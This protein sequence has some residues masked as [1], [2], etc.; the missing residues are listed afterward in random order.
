MKTTT[1]TAIFGVLALAVILFAAAYPAQ[2]ALMSAKDGADGSGLFEHLTVLMCLPGICAG[3]YI[4]AVIVPPRRFFAW[5]LAWTLALVY[6][7]GEE[8]SW[9]Q[10]YFGWETPESFAEINDQ[11]ETNLHNISSWLDMKPRILVE[12]FCF[13]TAFVL[14]LYYAAGGKRVVLAVFRLPV[15]FVPAGAVFTLSRIADWIPAN[16]FLKNMGNSEFRELIIACILSGYMVYLA[17]SR[18]R[19]KI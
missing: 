8:A 13:M 4:M 5:T 15:S 19:A 16:E 7:A 17:A 9:G 18:E 1:A 3:I 10:W 11:N 6:F 12:L 2:F 14:P